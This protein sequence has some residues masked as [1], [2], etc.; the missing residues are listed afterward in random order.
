MVKDQQGKL[1]SHCVRISQ[2]VRENTRQQLER[3]TSPGGPVEVEVELLFGCG[4][5]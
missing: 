5:R 2:A 3:K 4:R 1:M